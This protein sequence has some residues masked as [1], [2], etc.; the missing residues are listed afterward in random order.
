M[1]KRRKQLGRYVRPAL[2]IPKE[3][4]LTEPEKHMLRAAVEAGLVLPSGLARRL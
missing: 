2:T 3:R 1:S 4:Q